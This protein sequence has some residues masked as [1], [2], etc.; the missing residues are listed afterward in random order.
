[1]A[2]TTKSP[3]ASDINTG[4]SASNQDMGR[5]SFSERASNFASDTM[6]RAKERPWTSAAVVG[7]VAAA[8]AAAVYG[9][10]K[11]AQSYGSSSRSGK[12]SSSSKKS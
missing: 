12:S 3:S 10:T 4:T 5:G 8:A 11:L 1:M 2:T 6:E 9:G 7:G